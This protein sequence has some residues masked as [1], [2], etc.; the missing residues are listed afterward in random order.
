MVV[1]VTDGD[2]GGEGEDEGCGAGFRVDGREGSD[3]SSSS[4]LAAAA[5]LDLRVSVTSTLLLLLSC[6]C[7]CPAWQEV[8]RCRVATW[9]WGTKGNMPA[10]GI[11]RITRNTP[12]AVIGMQSTWRREEGL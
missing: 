1:E 4:S 12:V 10:A 8:H 3:V 5:E 11:G 2:E 7:R 9:K 6:V